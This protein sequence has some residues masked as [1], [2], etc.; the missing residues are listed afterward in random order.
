MLP[1]WPD[2][3]LDILL[4]ERRKRRSITASA[5]FQNQSPGQMAAEIGPPLYIYIKK[6]KWAPTIKEH[7]RAHMKIKLKA[8]LTLMGFPWKVFTSSLRY[9]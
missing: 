6:H 8:L 5:T 1:C 9:L 2:A 3:G 7:I 4:P